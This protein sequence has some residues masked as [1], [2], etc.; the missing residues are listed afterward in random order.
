MSQPLLSTKFNIPTTGGKI[1]GRPRLLRLLDASLE[2]NIR[3]TLVCGPAGYGKTTVVSDWLQSSKE[4]PPDQVAWLTIDIEDNDLTR[5][6]TYL[7]A[8]LQRISPGA[9]QGL[10]K[11]LHTHKPLPPAV[12][13]TLLINE[14]N[15]FPRRCFLV[16]DD[17]HLLTAKT[18]QS[19]MEFLVEHQSSQLCLVLITRNDPPLPLARLRA[20]GQLVELRQDSLSFLPEEAAEFTNQTMGLHLSPEEVSNL[21][22]KTEGW[23]SGLQLAAISLRKGEDQSNSFKLF[24]GEHEF[25]ADYLT[26]E[27]LSILPETLQTFLLQTSILERLSAPLCEAVTGL[28]GAQATLEQLIDFNL[29]IAPLDNQRTWYRYH[30]LFSDLLRKRLLSAPGTAVNELHIRASLWF[31][32][33]GLVDQSVEHALAGKDSPRAAGLIEPIAEQYLM[34]GETATL[35]RWLNALPEEEILAHPLLG[36]LYI[37][38]LII[39]GRSL[40]M[41]NTLLEKMRTSSATVDY[42]GEMLL[43]EA[44]AAILQGNSIRTIQYSDKALSYLRPDRPFLRS[45]AADMLGMGYTLAGDVPSAAQAFEQVVEISRQTDNVMMEIAALTNL[46]GLHYVQGKLRLSVD[47]CQQVLDLAQAR[48]GQD[49]PMIGKTLFTLGEIF[50]EQ[51][52]L[53][54]AFQYFLNASILMDR[55]TEIGS[56]LA[57]LSLARVRMSQKDWV[58]AQS[59]IDQ[60]RRQAQTTNST[61]MDDRLVELAQVRVWLW[62]GEIEKASRWIRDHGLLDRN[63]TESLA[64]AEQNAAL[65]ELFQS[66]TL[67]LIH[68]FLAQGQ[69]E[70]GLD[71]AARL[72]EVNERLGLKRRQVE[73]L[74]LKALAYQQMKALEKALDA[75]RAALMLAEPEGY[76]TT[77]VEYGQPMAYLLYQAVERKIF[78]A[79]AS[80]LLTAITNQTSQPGGK[81]N[82]QKDLIEPLSERE[83]EVLKLIA[84]GLSNSEIASRLHISL[85]TVKGHTANIFGKLGVHNRTQAVARANDLSI[86][87]SK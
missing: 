14:I 19:F 36:T 26:E 47:T 2:K 52:E 20:R 10:L 17:Y 38:I 55:F 41:M 24:S 8:A 61:Q 56:S 77:F 84:A 50:R 73:L 82:R 75:L 76:Q 42:Q 80:K 11:M 33:H 54:K 31:E 12:L 9:G 71:I 68:Y 7:V 39:S 81:E 6:V 70:Q 30:T 46:A 69:P 51:G 22:V 59:Y 15:D 44:F 28:T 63:F 43:S 27:V 87:K 16:L 5:L 45:L 60:A 74:V 4:I 85:S 67:I 66:E 64:A 86:L 21:T 34:R 65:N 79:Y 83:L 25:I 35:S 57:Y 1:I 29:F 53:N 58:D 32:Q 18:I 3:L 49:T 13:A 23:I 72:C 48:L 62:L 37:V 40:Q 78:P